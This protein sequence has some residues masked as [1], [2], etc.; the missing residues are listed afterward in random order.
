MAILK[1]S[2]TYTRTFLMVQSSDHI[3][4]ITGATVTVTLSKAG[5]SFAAAGG[6]VTEISSGWYKIALTTTD[7]N[8]LGDLAFHCTATSADPTDF[9]DQVTANILGDTLPANVTQ[10]N[11]SNVSSP[12]TAGIPDVNAKNWNN[13]ATV[14]L[15]LVPTVAGRTL[16]VSAGGEAG[17]DWANIGSP[18]TTVALTGTTIA[19]TQQVDVNTIKTQ[20]VTCTTGVTVSPFVGSTGAAVNGTNANTLSSHD[21]GTTLGTSTLT[22][23]QVTGGAFA[24]NSASFAFNAAL[25]FTTTQKAATLSHVTLV[26]TITTYTGNTPQ[27]GDSFARIG[28]TGSGLTS[29][30]PSATALSTAQWTNTLATNLGTTNT[31]VAAN[32]D[33]AVSTRMATFTLPANFSSLGITVAGKI[34]EVVLTDTL[35]TYTGNTPQTGDSFSRIGVAGVGLTNLGDARIADLDVTVSSRASATVA[36]SWYTA[37][38]TAPTAAQNATAVWTDLLAGS[39]FSTVGS[40]G[41]LLKDDIDATVSSRSTYAGGAVA[42]VTG[43]VGGNVAGSVGSVVTGVTVT[44]N[45]DKTGYSLTQAFPA[46]FAVLGITAAGKINEVVLTDTLT[47]YTGNTPQTGDAFARIGANGAGLTVLA[48]AA[49]MVKVLAAVYDS[50]TAVGNVLTL[51]NGATQTI[52]LTT[53]A[54]TTT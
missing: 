5:G 44:T 50:C 10:W 7:T 53:G 34:S 52:D 16:D 26:D 29:L 45:N 24:L 19:T 11:G 31:T 20:T 23:T 41:K 14:A 36:P 37:P 25:D 47:T 33:V 2:T 54:R 22:Q 35:T 40:I 17:L 38:G 6:I 13:L 48:S 27:T 32:L 46:N 21:P 28:A 1:Q 18:T 3:T 49:N 43:N 9:C 30:A 42:S 39:D 51:S 8:T 4:G 12:A 15:P